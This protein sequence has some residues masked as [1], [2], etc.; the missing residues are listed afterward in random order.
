LFLSIFHPTILLH[1]IYEIE[2][3]RLRQW[4]VTTLVLDVD[5]TLTTHDNPVPNQDVLRWLEQMKALGMKLVIL[6]NNYA[7]RVEPFAKRLGLDYTAR[8]W[9]PLSKGF[10]ETA[11]R[12]KVAPAEMAVVGDQIFTDVLGGNLFGA[13]TILVEPMEP[14]TGLGFRLKRRLEKGILRRYRQKR[15]E[16]K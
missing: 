13:K 16:A 6:S 4:G 9:K 11:R 15:G 8:A 1:R 14:E 10:R 2:P 12:L 5:N 7:Q 3:Q